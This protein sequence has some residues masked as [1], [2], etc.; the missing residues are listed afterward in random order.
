LHLERK[1]SLGIRWCVVLIWYDSTCKNW[2]VVKTIILKS[3]VFRSN[4][5]NI[6]TRSHLSSHLLAVLAKLKPTPN[7]TNLAAQSKYIYDSRSNKN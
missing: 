7:R 1:F 4:T 2:L 3:L 5:L 6:L